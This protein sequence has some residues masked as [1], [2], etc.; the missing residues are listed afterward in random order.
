MYDNIF[1]YGGR[2]S[3][4]GIYNLFANSLG[5]SKYLCKRYPAFML[6]VFGAY[7][8]LAEVED[9]P[10]FDQA[11]AL[12]EYTTI[13]NTERKD[14]RSTLLSSR[15]FLD[16]TIEKQDELLKF[17]TILYISLNIEDAA[18]DIIS[19]IHLRSTC[20]DCVNVIRNEN[21]GNKWIPVLMDQVG[22]CSETDRKMI[23]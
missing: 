13:K 11:D 5:N 6:I 19:L 21:L 17:L 23:L 15:R 8:S 4:F 10:I 12:R 18:K 3:K 9:S 2:C 14:H 22:R 16:L 1:F 7:E 20:L